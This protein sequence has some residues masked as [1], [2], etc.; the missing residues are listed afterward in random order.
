VCWGLVRRRP[1]WIP[2]WRG[3]VLLLTL[4]V[5]LAVL[6]LHNVHPFLAP[7]RPTYRGI[8]VVDG[9][10]P[11]YALQVALKTF[12][13]HDYELIVSVGVPLELGAAL[14]PYGTAAELGA[15]R[16]VLMGLSPDSVLALPVPATIRERTYNSAL[17]F[18][19]WLEQSGRSVPTVDL[20]SL[21]PHTRRSWFAFERVLGER[22]EVGSIAVPPTT[23][24]PCRWWNSSQG[25]RTVIGELIAYL[26][27]WF[28]R[29]RPVLA[30]EPAGPPRALRVDPR[31]LQVE[32]G[33]AGFDV[34]R[35]WSDEA[36]APSPHGRE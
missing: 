26:Y 36:F 22:L 34:V 5:S 8:L 30:A 32:P 7:T 11:D 12:R 29:P 9:W 16:L 1:L 19:R 10:V 18:G 20:L 25:T 4:I 17:T 13:S 31:M 3:V 15:D 14:A 21:G 27:A 35:V 28:L 24:D 2:T 33:G 6:L 23:Y